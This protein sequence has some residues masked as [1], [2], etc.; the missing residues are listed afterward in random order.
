VKPARRIW[1]LFAV[2]ACLASVTRAGSA[3][4][5]SSST[6]LPELPPAPSLDVGRPTP[7]EVEALNARLERICSSE[8]EEREAAAREALEV[9]SKLVPALRMR[10]SSLAEASNHEEMKQLLLVTRKEAHE[11]VD[12]QEPSSK[13]KK[14]AD[15]LQL[16]TEHASP[17]SKTWCQ[18]ASVL[19]ESRMLAQIGTVE[20]VRGLI[21]VYVRFG[22]FMRIDTQLQLD[23]LGE[24]GVPALIEARRHP[25]EKIAKWAE[26]Q[27]DALGKGIPGETVRTS[28]LQVLSDVL[29]AYGRVRDPDA[30]RI[31]V[32]FANSERAQVR[33]ASRQAIAL[34]GEVGAWQLR[35]TYESVVGKKPPRDWNWERT[36][37]E[38]FA[39]FDRLRS[40]EVSKLFDAGVA[41][42]QNGDFDSMRHAFDR[43]LA[44]SPDYPKHDE[45]AAGYL[46]FAE[47]EADK[48]PSDAVDALLRAERLSKGT[49]A[50]HRAAALRLVLQAEQ[51]ASSGVADVT[52]LNR[53]LELDANCSRAKAALARFQH[54][55]LKEEPSSRYVAAAAIGATALFSI[56]FV[57]LRR[58]APPVPVATTEPQPPA[59]PEQPTANQHIVEQQAGEL[60]ESAEHKTNE[61]GSEEP[62]S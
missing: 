16:V 31:I 21:D 22:E 19:A 40:A 10:L 60:S 35:D 4:P 62:G 51:L 34:L 39:E 29:R 32:S 48:R 41:A 12:E 43:V 52:L 26:K 27:L 59:P 37:R 24:R 9:D 46:A 30:A 13:R 5:S 53:A 57:L 3:E 14:S 25:A 49:D 54:G 42:R 11:S 20:A 6:S 50:E 7:T 2:L 33:E 45:L 1:R 8:A 15:Y 44:R 56:L 23:G 18:L 28:N 61:P 17:K 55:E 36:A 47:K 58:E 38:L